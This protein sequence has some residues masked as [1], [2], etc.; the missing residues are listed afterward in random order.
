MIITRKTIPRRTMLRGLGAAIALPLLDGMVPAL[1]PLRAT[2]AAPRRRFGIVYVPHGAV[3]DRWTPSVDSEALELSPILQ[4]L[5]PFR[6]R[7]VVLTGLDNAPALAL[8]GEPAGGHG[9]IGARVRAQQ[10]GGRSRGAQEQRHAEQDL[11]GVDH[12][13]SLFRRPR[14]R[15]APGRW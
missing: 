10:Q 15:P 12:R 2:A 6:N 9:R 13:P 14:S 5:A 11:N 3:M 7:T 8:A 4:P 1:A